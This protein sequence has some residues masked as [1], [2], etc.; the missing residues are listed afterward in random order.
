ML[1]KELEA[2]V[3]QIH[4]DA[5]ERLSR[6]VRER[7]NLEATLEAKIAEYEQA[8]QMHYRS[9]RYKPEPMDNPPC[10]ACFSMGMSSVLQA[11]PAGDDD[12]DVLRCVQCDFEVKAHE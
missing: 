5:K 4:R 3:Q 6:I 1:V 10:P 9:S 8:Q 7:D 2:A 11:L 12:R